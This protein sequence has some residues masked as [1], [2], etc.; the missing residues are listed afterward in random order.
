VRI[1]VYSQELTNEIDRVTK[2]GTDKD[3]KA[4]QFHAV[5]LYLHSAP[6]LH[7]TPEDDDRSALTIWLPRDLQRRV[8]LAI[9]L[10]VLAAWAEDPWPGGWPGWRD[11]P[12]GLAVKAEAE[13]AAEAEA[14]DREHRVEI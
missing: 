3:G 8:D 9:A 11:G 6:Q 5:R 2:L 4:A 12:E 10:R 13:H 7:H 1:N 14:E